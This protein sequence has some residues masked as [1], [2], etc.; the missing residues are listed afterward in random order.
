MAEKGV[1]HPKM[2]RFLELALPFLKRGEKLLAFSNF[3][4]TVDRLRAEL[5]QRGIKA[6]AVAGNEFMKPKEQ[7]LVLDEFRNGGCSALIATTVIEAGIHV[8]KIDVVINYSMPLTGIAQIQRGG[9]AGRTAVGLIYYL[10][11]D[12]SNDSSLYYAART[13]NKKLGDE[14]RQRMFVQTA[15]LNG[16]DMRI[17]RARQEQLPLELDVCNVRF[18][19]PRRTKGS[20]AA[21]KKSVGIQLDLF[22]AAEGGA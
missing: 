7:R 11:M 5:C 21:P 1:L 16:E 8:P 22:C 6:L 14:M 12:N 20:R 10:I 19:R 4:Q 9:R 3:K 15:E 13:E 18:E 2:E 17:V